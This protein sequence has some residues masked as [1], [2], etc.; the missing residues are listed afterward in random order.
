[1]TSIN[2]TNTVDL[3]SKRDAAL[4]NE[5]EL[6]RTR[7]ARK[8]HELESMT[9]D[10][11]QTTKNLVNLAQETKDA[12]VSAAVR[13]KEFLNLPLM[14]SRY[15]LGFVAVSFGVGWYLGRPKA[16]KYATVRTTIP[17]QTLTVVAP[18][19]DGMRKSHPFMTMAGEILFTVAIGEMNRYLQA[20]RT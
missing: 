15:P 16:S 7:L 18:L 8:I 12:V 14:F 19:K 9:A 2:L 1:M 5:V 11:V 3:D 17:E 13:A 6:R 4:A 20:R 10:T